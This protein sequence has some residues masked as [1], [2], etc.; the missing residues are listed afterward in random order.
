MSNF[1]REM[2][3]LR[4]PLSMPR[5]PVLVPREEGAQPGVKATEIVEVALCRQVS[6]LWKHRTC[7][8]VEI[9]SLAS[10][11]SAVVTA[12]ECNTLHAPIPEGSSCQALHEEA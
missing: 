11:T 8:N 3:L 6:K 5:H 9:A 2:Y 1:L 4:S 10:G 12:S 7:C